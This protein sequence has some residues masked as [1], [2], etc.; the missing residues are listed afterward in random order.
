MRDYFGR[1]PLAELSAELDQQR[2]QE[3][4]AC[5][6]AWSEFI[7]AV[8]E[9]DATLD[10]LTRHSQLLAAAILVLHG[11][12]NHHGEWRRRRVFKTKH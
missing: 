11:F 5:D 3:Q 8:E 9:G 7:A 6:T 1:G 10:D 4:A 12:H 2:R